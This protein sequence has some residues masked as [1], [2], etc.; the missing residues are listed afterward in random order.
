VKNPIVSFGHFCLQFQ[1]VYDFYQTMVGGVRYRSRIVGELG[2]L[3]KPSFLDL[4]CGTATIAR[5]LNS[6]VKYIGIDNSENYLTKAKHD[7][8][9]HKFLNKNLSEKNW[10]Q[11]LLHL[12]PVVASGLGLLHHLDDKSAETF[13]GSCREILDKDSLLFTVDPVIVNDTNKIA[14]WFANNDRGKF[15]RSPEQMQRIFRDSGFKADIKIKKLQ[16]R[17]PLDTVEVTASLI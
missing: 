1:A 8:P 4:G 14:R 7:F 3:N 12:G 6:E 11:E 2:Q 9:Q 16:F 5:E 17:I 13:L 15:I 10:E